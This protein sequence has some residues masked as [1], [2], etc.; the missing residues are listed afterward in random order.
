METSKYNDSIANIGNEID[1]N[2]NATSS[3]TNGSILE[4]ENHFIQEDDR[5]NET[6]ASASQD[7]KEE[8]DFKYLQEIQHNNNNHVFFDNQYGKDSI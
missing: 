4:T 3:N 2:S 1:H 5:P 6:S 8:F 7:S